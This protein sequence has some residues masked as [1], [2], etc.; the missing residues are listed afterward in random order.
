M[1]EVKLLPYVKNRS[2]ND[3]IFKQDKILGNLNLSYMLNA[4]YLQTFE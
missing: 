2:I 3:V 1:L 4:I